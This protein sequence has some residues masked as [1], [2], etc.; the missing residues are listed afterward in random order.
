MC[1]IVGCM[2]SLKQINVQRAEKAIEELERMAAAGNICARSPQVQR[3][4]Q[5][6]EDLGHEVYYAFI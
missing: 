5:L 2:T 6:L 1:C 4:V 3:Q